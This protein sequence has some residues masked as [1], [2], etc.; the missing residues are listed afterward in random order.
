MWKPESW[1]Y[2]G[3]TLVLKKYSTALKAV[4]SSNGFQICCSALRCVFLFYLNLPLVSYVV[5]E[6]MQSDLHKIIVS[7]QPLSSDHAK[8][9]LYQILR[10]MFSF[11][12]LFLSQHLVVTL[13]QFK[14]IQCS[15]I[16]SSI[17][18]MRLYIVF[19]G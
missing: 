9:F 1:W 5:T 18:E 7:P 14:S 6:L 11:L 4:L 16:N 13:I 12:S 15:C 2:W 19:T 3:L 8:V 10:G 17:E